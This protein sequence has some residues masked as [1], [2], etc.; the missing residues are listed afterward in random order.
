MLQM[1][2]I[3]IVVCCL[4]FLSGCLHGFAF[5]GD[6]RGLIYNQQAGLASNTVDFIGSDSEGYLYFCTNRGL[7]IFD[8]NIF[9]NYNSQNTPGFSNNLTTIVELDNYHLLIGSRDK[10]LFILDKYKSR[11]RAVRG[12]NAQIQSVNT[13][14]KTEKGEIWFGGDDGTLWYVEDY[15]T[16]LAD[17]DE[18]VFHRIIYSFSSI[19]ALTEVDNILF[20]ATQS[21]Q[22]VTICRTQE[23]VVVEKAAVLPGAESSHSFLLRNEKELWVGTNTGVV[24]FNKKEK[25]WVEGS[26]FAEKIGLVRSMA[27]CDDKI[28][29][30]TEGNGLFETDPN[31]LTCTRVEQKRL[32]FSGINLNYIISLKTDYSGNLWVGTWLGGVARFMFASSLFSSYKNEE[33]T[34]NLFSNVVWAVCRD[35]FRKGLFLGTHGSG[36]CRYDTHEM[37]F[38][39]VDLSF[40]SVWTLY[41]DSITPFLYVGTWGEGLRLYDMQTAKYIPVFP[42]EIEHE[43]IYSISRYNERELFIGTSSSGVWLFNEERKEICPL[44]FPG[45]SLSHLNVRCIQKDNDGKGF[46]MATFNAG[47]FH[48]ELD[49]SGKVTDLERFSFIGDEPIQATALFQDGKYIWICMTNGLACLD[50]A[51]SERKIRRISQLDGFSLSDIKKSTDGYFWICSH[52]GLLLFDPVKLY[53][54]RYLTKF[55]HYR[56][57]PNNMGGLLTGTSEGLFSFEPAKVKE[58]QGKGRALIRS[59]EMNGQV[60]VPDDPNGKV[61]INKAINY[62]DTLVLPPGNANI[63]FLLSA[64]SPHVYGEHVLFYRMEGLEDYWNRTSLNNS[65]AVYGNLPS[66]KYKFHVRLNDPDNFSGEKELVVIKKEF[67]WNTIYARIVYC[68][69]FLS[70]VIYLIFYFRKKY[71]TSYIRRVQDVERQKE[72]EL[73]FQ[74]IRFFTNISHDLKTPLTLLLTPL[75]DLLKHPEIPETFRPRLQSMYINGDLLLKKINK[76]LNYRNTEGEDTALSV[77]VYSAHQLLYEIIAPFKEYAE[78]QGLYFSIQSLIENKVTSAIYTDRNKLESILENLI[79][80][81]IKYT[82]EGGEVTVRY[83]IDNGKLEL[84]V[85]DTG[86]GI[87][88]EALPHIFERYYR[89]AADNRGT[90]IG[91]FLVKHYVNLLEGDISVTSELGIGTTFRLSLPIVVSD[92]ENSTDLPGGCEDDALQ[93][94]DNIVRI[95][96]VDDN[97]EMRDYLRQLFSPFYQVVEASDGKQA[98][99]IVR[100]ELPDIILSD[101]MMSDVDGLV[102]CR[103][104]KGDMLTSHIPF[105]ILSAK[106]S[107]ETRLECWDAGVDLFEEKPFNSQ[108]LLTKVAN[109]LRSRKLLKYKYQIAFPVSILHDEKEE[110]TESLEERFLKEVNAAIDKHKDKPDLS[111]RELGEELHMRHDQLYRKLKTLTGLSANQYIRT[112]R[113]NCAAAML[114]SKKYMVTEVLYSVGFN[115]PSY[116]TKCFKKEFG[117]LPSEYVAQMEEEDDSVL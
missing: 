7:S 81:A 48:F 50:K 47:L 109:L 104:I 35:K 88:A 15:K 90:G 76:I 84:D 40:R 22:L 79:S 100:I 31:T 99:E 10:G 26:L 27:I 82:P 41:T 113:L 62:A 60:I 77:E 33:N 12:S 105:I 86:T 94:K 6:S 101:L 37:A 25:H 107:V 24:V 23:T 3:K 106:S 57:Y 19:N 80:N 13:V 39:T 14:L 74:K 36:L 93:E 64:F 69:L 117:V 53:V 28:Y 30:G 38:Q 103:N 114:R 34:P 75:N 54:S 73:Y 29:I 8:G 70:L 2:H 71:K 67:W 95:L 108:L 44:A 20:V 4:L 83:S 42:S 111:V 21:N 65:S 92:M 5:N 87:Q 89:I 116:F 17:S 91:L 112:Y 16:L 115:N 18:I 45:D 96:V 72:E 1:V 85:S 78:R 102:L 51:D 46:W 66:G 61:R 32:P 68:V 9:T 98:M 110:G 59:L 49:Q 58:S 97:K 43:R 52:E 56:I 63:S 55:I 11:I